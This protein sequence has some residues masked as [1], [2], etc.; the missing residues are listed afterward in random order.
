MGLLTSSLNSS[1][2]NG[3]WDKKRE[4]IKLKAADK[5]TC[6][7]SNNEKWTEPQIKRRNKSLAD[8]IS[9]VITGPNFEKN[10]KCNW[11]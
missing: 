5:T 6:I 2:S 7:A 3:P 11:L 9:K 10:D 8:K 4:E 1:I